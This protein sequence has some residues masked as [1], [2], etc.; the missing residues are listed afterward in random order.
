LDFDLST[1]Q[2]KSDPTKGSMGWLFVLFIELDDGNIYRKPVYLMVR[3]M[4]S[5]RFSLTNPLI[6]DFKIVQVLI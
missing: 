6:Y 5:C 4:V 1:D 3:T 2:D